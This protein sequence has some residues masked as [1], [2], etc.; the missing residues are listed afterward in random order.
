MKRSTFICGI[1]TTALSFFL[2]APAIT[3]A[4]PEETSSEIFFDDFNEDSLDTSKWLVADKWWG[5]D[6]GGVVPENVSVSDA[7]KKEQI[8]LK[9]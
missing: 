8:Q 5:G 7:K 4:A 3:H 6:N 1:L 9:D 2:A